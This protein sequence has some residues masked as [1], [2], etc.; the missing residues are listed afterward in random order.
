MR[1]ILLPIHEPN[2]RPVR[3]PCPAGPVLS[4]LGII[5]LASTTSATH[6]LHMHTITSE[7]RYQP[8]DARSSERAA[9]PRRL[10]SDPLDSSI[11][12]PRNAQAT[13]SMNV[14]EG[15]TRQF[16]NAVAKLTA[17]NTS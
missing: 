11:G 17:D 15:H 8:A 2:P 9:V 6:S 13:G 7:A 12:L 10:G 5:H 1:R 4:P 14:H 3:G 16:R